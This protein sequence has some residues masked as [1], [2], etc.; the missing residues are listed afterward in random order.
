MI[1]KLFFVLFVTYRSIRNAIEYRK[2]QRMIGFVNHVF[3]ME[4]KDECCL[5][6]FVNVK[7]ERWL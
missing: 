5:V 2:F 6:H 3:Y 7:E 1:I 4:K